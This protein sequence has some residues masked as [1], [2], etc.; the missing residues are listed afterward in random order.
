MSCNRIQF[1]LIMYVWHGWMFILITHKKS[2]LFQ[3]H[4]QSSNQFSRKDSFISSNENSLKRASSL[5]LTSYSIKNWST[6]YREFITSQ[7]TV[8]FAESENFTTCRKLGTRAT[9]AFCHNS[10]D[11]KNIELAKEFSL[12]SFS[13]VRFKRLISHSYTLLA[14]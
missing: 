7:V 6:Y 9:F 11:A 2:W 3:S 8:V 5:L 13:F 14:S 10:V 4:F 12:Y 1:L